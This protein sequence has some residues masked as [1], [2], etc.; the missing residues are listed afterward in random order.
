MIVEIKIVCEQKSIFKTYSIHMLFR[1]QPNGNA[2]P[3]YRSRMS[4]MV[5]LEVSVVIL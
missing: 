1:H 3:I 2:N 4:E 5:S